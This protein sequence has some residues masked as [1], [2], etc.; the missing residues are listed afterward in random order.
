MNKD[1]VLD[2]LN[3]FKNRLVIEVVQSFEERGSSFGN[4]RFSTWKRKFTQFLSDNLSGEESKFNN[5]LIR[6]GMVFHRGESDAQ[7]FW[8]EYGDSV[9]SYIDSLIL[10]IEN[11][12][13]D[14]PTIKL[15][16][17]E[18]I[19]NPEIDFESVFIVHGHA[20]AEKERTARFVEKLGFKAIILHEQPNKSMTIIEKLERNSNVGFAIVLYTP[21]DLGNSKVEAEGEYAK[22][23]P[24]PRQNVVLEHGFLM[25]KIGRDKVVPLVVGDI[26]LPNDI[27]GMVYIT[28]KDWQLDIAKE[29]KAAGFKIDF[30]KLM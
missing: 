11:D 6:V 4:D 3:T 18:A 24:R 12:E 27:S 23:N 29:M 1:E 28:D 14:P 15:E 5:K 30:N 16:K 17:E 9:V 7:Y 20:E 13:Y 2:G 25:G 8:R 26:E 21:D 10:D 19:V 22:F